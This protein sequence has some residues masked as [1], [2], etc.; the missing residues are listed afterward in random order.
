MRPSQ[1]QLFLNPPFL[2]RFLARFFARFLARCTTTLGP[3]LG[4][5]FGTHFAHP[6]WDPFWALLWVS[7]LRLALCDTRWASTVVPTLGATSGLHFGPTFWA[8][9][10]GFT[11]GPT[12]GFT[13]AASVGGIP[14]PNFIPW[15]RVPLGS[16][17]TRLGV[18]TLSLTFPTA[19]CTNLDAHFGIVSKS[20]SIWPH[21]GP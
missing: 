3:T 12:L 9:T 21:Q 10:L 13:C 11:L 17:V 7:I 2:F 14:A 6:L 5:H 4:T 8:F 18:T 20:G 19:L 16:R 1:S 15:H